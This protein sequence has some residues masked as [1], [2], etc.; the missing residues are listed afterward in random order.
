MG[1]MVL[2]ECVYAR[3]DQQGTLYETIFLKGIDRDSIQYVDSYVNPE[4]QEINRD[5]SMVVERSG[6]AHLTFHSV[7]DVMLALSGERSEV[8]FKAN[9]HP[10]GSYV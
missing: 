6:A 5:R 8:G 1:R 2:L 4:T 7:M 3:V 10:H 9:P